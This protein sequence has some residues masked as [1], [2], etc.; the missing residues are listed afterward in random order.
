MVFN[1]IIELICYTSLSVISILLNGL[2]PPSYS[3]LLFVND[4]Y[5]INSDYKLWRS[6]SYSVRL[7]GPQSISMHIDSIGWDEE[8]IVV[9]QYD[10]LFGVDDEPNWSKPNYYIIQLEDDTLIGPLSPEEYENS[11]YSYLELKKI[12][13]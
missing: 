1:R 5:V 13:T 11:E 8:Y 6:S 4:E 2:V 12:N 7:I 3:D 9:L 10:Y